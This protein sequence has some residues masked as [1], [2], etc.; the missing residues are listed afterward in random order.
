LKLF[1]ILAALLFAPGVFSAP[2]EEIL[3]KAQGYP[4]C[5]LTG[6]G[7]PECLV[8]NYSNFDKIVPARKV[9]KS[10]RMR[11]LARAPSEPDVGVDQFLNTTRITGL[12]VIRGDN[13]LVERYQ[14]DR[15]PEHRFTSMSMAKTVVAMLF[16]IALHE[17]KISSLDDRAEKYV[18][19]LKGHPYGET[20]LRHLLTMSSGVRFSEDYGG[21]DDVAVLART[22]FFQQGPGGAATVLP[23]KDRERDPGKR[24]SYASAETQVL[25][26]VVRAAAGKPLAD[27]LSEKVWQPM[28]AEFDASWLIDAGGYEIAYCCIN[29]TLR[30]WGRL[31]MLLANDGAVDGRQII[32]AAWVREA[33]T[34]QASHLQFGQATRFMGYGYQTWLISPNARRFALLGIRGQA[35]FVDPDTKTVVVNT[36]IHPM[37]RDPASNSQFRFFDNVLSSARN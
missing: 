12:L 4:I 31:G 13:V 24:F 29:A 25:G 14:Y 17:G 16:G 18:P 8:G 37:P 23:F 10:G 28:G 2:D 9:A 33:T 11:P 5:Q 35:I 36:A 34:A 3:G 21:K 19:E 32:P 6:A 15:N 30:D 22:T 1:V 27:Y 26:L 20:A 7:R